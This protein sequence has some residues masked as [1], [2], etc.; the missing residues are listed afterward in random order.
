MRRLVNHGPGKAAGIS[1]MDFLQVPVRIPV[2]GMVLFCFLGLGGF[3][4]WI[5]ILFIEKELNG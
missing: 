3:R 5:V 1:S 2:K 4:C